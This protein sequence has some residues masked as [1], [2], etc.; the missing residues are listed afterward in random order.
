VATYITPSMI[1]RSALATLYNNAV[2]SQLISRDY[3]AD[4]TGKVGDTVTVRTPA[5]FEVDEFDRSTGIVLQDPTEGSFDVKLDTIPDVSFPVTSEDLTLNIDDFSGRLLAPAM[6]A[7]VQYLDGKLADVLVD[8]ANDTGGGGVADGTAAPNAAWRQARAIL[9]RN[10]LPLTERYALLSP[11][12]VADALSDEL[13]VTANQSGSTDALRNANI[14]RIFGFDNYE[15]QVLGEGGATDGTADGVAFHRS[16]VALV[17]RTLE[18]PMGVAPDQFA[19]ENYKGFGL[20]VVRDYDI[21]KKQDVISVD[22][23]YGIKVVRKQAAVE[24]DFGQ[25]S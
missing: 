8:A 12:A 16:A 17:T 7:I 11:E 1:A 18:K 20:R 13:I 14:G 2:L 19:V 23:L 6:E 3:D 21:D 10:K 24:L 9:S 25:G 4:F 22:F 15:S 5:V